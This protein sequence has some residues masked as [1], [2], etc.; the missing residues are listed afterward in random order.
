[1]YDISLSA[2]LVVYF[3]TE[4]GDLADREPP[5]GNKML[6]LTLKIDT[7]VATTSHNDQWDY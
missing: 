3:R 7:V 1:L 6:L 4:L 5:E 2:I